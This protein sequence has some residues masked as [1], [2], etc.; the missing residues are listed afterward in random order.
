MSK[1]EIPKF[2]AKIRE[3]LKKIKVSEKRVNELLGK[4]LSLW[5]VT[6]AIY[7]RRFDHGNKKTWLFYQKVNNIRHKLKLPNAPV[8]FSPLTTVALKTYMEN[9]T[10]QELRG[11][12]VRAPQ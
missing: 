7:N 9:H 6:E 12:L 10:E 3:Q 5:Q 8:K 4:G 11:L 2:N 1:S